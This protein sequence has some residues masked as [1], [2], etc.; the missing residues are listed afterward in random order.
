MTP[1][2]VSPI[3][4]DAPIHG[5]RG[6]VLSDLH[7][8][9]GRERRTL[10]AW[11]AQPH[12]EYAAWVFNGD[13]LDLKW[14][15]WPPEEAAKRA[16]DWMIAFA[17]AHPH[18]QIHWVMGNHDGYEAMRHVLVQASLPAN[19]H[20]HAEYCRLGAYLF[21]HGDLLL[22]KTPRAQRFWPVLPPL[23]KDARTRARYEHPLQL[24]LHFSAS[25]LMQPQLLVRWMGKHLPRLH[26]AEWAAARHIITGHTHRPY[27]QFSHL[28]K[29]WSNTG[30]AVQGI[31]FEPLEFAYA[32][33]A[34]SSAG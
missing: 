26:P 34:V 27:R 12:A 6:I 13:I 28:G 19:L 3:P 18:A 7:L 2:V 23:P 21:L 1:L 30:S 15:P 9:S 24:R 25:L 11:L 32:A 31:R 16:C 29:D 17:H 10:D 33:T 8:F 20:W 5:P 4:L 22:L 14:A